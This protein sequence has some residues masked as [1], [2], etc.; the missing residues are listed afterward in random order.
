MITFGDP[1]ERLA[2]KLHEARMV[3]CYGNWD[4]P[5][6]FAWPTTREGWQHYQ[7]HPHSAILQALAQAKDVAPLMASQ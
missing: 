7:H 2:A 6:R 4:L 1:I 5:S 3:E